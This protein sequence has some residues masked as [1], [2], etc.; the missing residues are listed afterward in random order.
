MTKGKS[1]PVGAFNVAVQFLKDF[2][3]EY[4]VTEDST[5]IESGNGKFLMKVPVP[6]KSDFLVLR[7][8]R[9]DATLASIDAHLLHDPIKKIFH[10]HYNRYS[11]DTE[12]NES[13]LDTLSTL[14]LMAVRNGVF[15]DEEPVDNQSIYAVDLKDIKRVTAVKTIKVIEQHQLSVSFDGQEPVGLTVP[16][17]QLHAFTIGN[18][19]AK[20][21]HVFQLIEREGQLH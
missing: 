6:D 20:M 14:L 13:R 18:K 11:G 4:L 19:L 10:S 12:I 1:V 16:K 15:G 8:V 21:G 5:T 9:I 17:E 7:C 2:V 3:N